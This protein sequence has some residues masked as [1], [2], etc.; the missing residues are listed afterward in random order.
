MFILGG[1]PLET[2][3]L[4]TKNWT[5]PGVP[6]ATDRN[7]RPKPPQAVVVHTV[8]GIRGPLKPGL[9]TS[10]RAEAYARYQATSPRNVSWDFTVDTDGTIVQS[11]DPLVYAT[12]QS[13]S[14]LINNISMGFEM[15][16][17]EDGSLYEGQLD[18][19]VKFL[20]FLTLHLG[21]QRQL[22]TLTGKPDFRK[23]SRMFGGGAGGDVYGIYGHRN[24]SHDR[25]FGDPGDWAFEALLKAGYEGFDFED[26]QDLAAWKARQAGLGLTGKDCDGQPGPHTRELLKNAGKVG[27]LWV[28][29]P[30]DE[31]LTA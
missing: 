16:Q 26:K 28:T 1:K 17:D 4:E 25:G 5:D 8:H 30:V 18:V 20:D 15:V 7:H 19:V 3:G 14:S 9:R 24:C 2:P 22:P 12:W 6:E 10:Q 21:I 11:N 23:L 27:G 31:L 29:R 13:G